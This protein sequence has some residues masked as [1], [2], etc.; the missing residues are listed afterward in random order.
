MRKLAYL[1]LLTATILPASCSGDKESKLTAEARELFK[2]TVKLTN[3]YADSI[4]RASDS[5]NI[6]RLFAAYDENL[7]KLN[8]EYPPD[9]DLD[10]NEGQNDTLIRLSRKIVLLRDS[11]LAQAAHKPLHTDSI[12]SDSIAVT[13]SLRMLK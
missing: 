6:N 12:T 10:M 11:M 3:L 7:T 8:F 5:L 2:K 4:S 1:V 13:D 9:A